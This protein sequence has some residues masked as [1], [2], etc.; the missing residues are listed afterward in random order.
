MPTGTDANGKLRWGILGT[1]EIARVFAAGLA[2]TERGTLTAVATRSRPADDL[3][4]AFPG[5]EIHIGYE[6]LL[7]DPNIDA[8]YV[9]TP[10]PM[11]V[12]NASAAIAAGKHVLC[13]KPVG[14]NAEEAE[15]LVEA[16][17]RA[18]VFLGEA[19]MYRLHPQMA[20]VC[21][22]VREGRV[23]RVRMVQASFG[24]RKEFE[25]DHRL[26]ANALAGGGILDV[27]G[28]PMSFARLVAGAA[29][30]KPF[31]DPVAIKAFGELGE[32]G[33]DHWT[34]AIAHFDDGLVAQLSCGVSVALENVARVHGEAGTIEIAS[35]WLA[36]GRAG[37]PTSITI[38]DADGEREVIDFPRERHLYAF[39]ADA[40]AE[41]VAAGRREFESPGASLADTL[42][43]M[44]SLD[45]WRSEIGLE[46]ASERAAGAA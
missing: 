25:A 18:D 37:G 14:I 38:I 8:V 7:A 5:A 1:G 41:A 46:Y 30:G 28:Y 32:T 36:G 11:H 16:A 27:G 33:V 15:T 24:F 17:K 2:E 22:L 34:A 19:F 40:A 3:A 6:A 31:R 20:R 29:V 4:E 42:G 21:A 35:P 44:R 45:A 26:F 10:H 39:E 13:E 23:G 12:A 9:A 43:N